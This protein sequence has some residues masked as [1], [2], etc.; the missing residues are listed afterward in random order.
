MSWKCVHEQVMAWL[1]DIYTMYDARTVTEI[2]TERPVS[3]SSAEED[4][5]RREYRI[6]NRAFGRT[7][8]RT[9]LTPADC[10]PEMHEVSLA[11]SDT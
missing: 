4:L 10:F 5:M 9:Q 6:L 2:V 3:S 1:V 7:A 11:S 8:A